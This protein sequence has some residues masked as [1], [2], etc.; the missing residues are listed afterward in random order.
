MGF[1]DILKKIF[2]NKA[3][4]DL[5]EIE[6]YVEKIKA[7]YE[8]VKTLNNDE[9][10]DLS[11]SLKLKIQQY[12]EPEVKRIAELK[13]SIEET[14]INLREK[15]YNEIDKLEKEVVEKYEKVL[16]EITPEAFSIVKDTARRLSEN[17]EV[18]VTANDFDRDLAAKHDF[19]TINGDKAHYKNEWTAGGNLIK[20][21]MVHYDVQL[22]GGVV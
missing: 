12:V 13:A 14:E 1:N 9:L 15:I 21:E 18:I 20:W 5:K 2:G 4:R 22:F 19:V 10:R 17:S 16:E 11:E 3:Q 7:A 6:P 8:K